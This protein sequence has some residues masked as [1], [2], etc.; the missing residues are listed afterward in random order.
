MNATF[1]PTPLSDAMLGRPYH[2]KGAGREHPSPW[3]SRTTIDAGSG[4]CA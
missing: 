4:P 2:D 3:V 1:M